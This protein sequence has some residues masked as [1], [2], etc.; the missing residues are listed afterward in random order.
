MTSTEKLYRAAKEVLYILEP[1][2]LPERKLIEKFARAI[3]GYERVQK[4]KS[5]PSEQ[6]GQ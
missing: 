6:S 1:L 4:L 3:K 2:N 5:I